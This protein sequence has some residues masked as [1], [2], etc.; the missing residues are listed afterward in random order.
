MI[1]TCF[2]LKGGQNK[3]KSLTSPAL[4][5]TPNQCPAYVKLAPVPLSSL[6][7]TRCTTGII[8]AKVVAGK[9]LV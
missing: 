3:K 2:T 7:P 8:G 9:L 6:L 4:W 1:V 5:T